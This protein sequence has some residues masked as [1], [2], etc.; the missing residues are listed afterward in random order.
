MTPVTGKHWRRSRLGK[1]E[2]PA[3]SYHPADTDQLLFSSPGEHLCPSS[4][5]VTVKLSNS[6]LLSARPRPTRLPHPD[7][8]EL[9]RVPVT[10]WDRPFPRSVLLLRVHRVVRRRA[11]REASLRLLCPHRRR[12]KSIPRSLSMRASQRQA[13]RSGWRME[14]GQLSMVLSEIQILAHDANF[15]F[16]Q[17]CFPIESEPHRRRHPKVHLISPAGSSSVCYHDH[18]PEQDARG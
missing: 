18:L 11:C 14:Q 8:C 5:F 16:G 9:S 1:T 10:D 4:T 13:C 12:T 7:L 3:F 6:E 15:S 17:A 2:L